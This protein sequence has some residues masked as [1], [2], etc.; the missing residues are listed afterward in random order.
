[1]H[2]SICICI[3][4]IHFNDSVQFDDSLIPTRADMEFFAQCA[5]GLKR[6]SLRETR[7]TS[8]SCEMNWITL[9]NWND[10][11]EL[12]HH[13]IYCYL[14]Y[15]PINNKTCIIYVYALLLIE[16]YI[17]IKHN[18]VCV[19]G[20][21]HFDDSIQF[22]DSMTSTRTDSSRNAQSNRSE[23]HCEWRGVCRARA[24]LIE[25]NRRMKLESSNCTIQTI[26][27]Y[28]ARLTV[29]VPV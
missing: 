26:Y 23:W 15:I 16:L 25:S 20:T 5:V 14:K 8:N 17:D 7:R 10:I 9:S 22:D 18:S 1:M 12:Y 6:M 21:I 4:T 27:Y 24:K 11:V 2:L 29:Q 3:Y 19:D 13:N 28:F